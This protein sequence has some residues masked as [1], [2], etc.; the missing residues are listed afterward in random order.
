MQQI[1]EN[2]KKIFNLNGETA[3][4]GWSRSAVFE[5]NRENHPAENKITEKDS[6]FISD[7]EMAFYL[8]LEVTGSDLSVKLILA[9]SKT[10][11]IVSD[12]VSKRMLLE[13]LKL[14]A[15]DSVG[16]FTYTDK[17]IALTI[18][19]TIGGKYLKCDFI[20]FGN[21]KN[22]FVKLF[23][24]NTKG[25]SM[26]MVSADGS[27]KQNF[28]FKRFAENF[29]ASGVV[30]FGG[31]DYDINE[32]NSLVY[33]TK[34]RCLLNRKKR[35]QALC[36]CTDVS[37]HKLSVNL[38]SKVSDRRSGSENAYFVDNKL[39]KIG[40]TRVAGDERN[41]YGKWDFDSADE[42]LSLEFTPIEKDGEPMLCRCGK[43]TIVFGRLNGFLET[44]SF[45]IN[46]KNKL[47]HMIFTSL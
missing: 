45:R 38:A 17:K 39:I 21:I 12:S 3:F 9:N 35:F 15:G 23:I 16:E 22:L 8:S 2:T 13:P 25:E 47:F 32:Q 18:T 37:G 14:P 10:G 1:V 19:N 46:L 27:D 24:K 6:Y 44:D 20:D 41:P 11:E 7:G 42:N 29:T 43:L 31:L 4:S 33:Y 28:Y 30:R 34:T 40:R 5:Y 36:G 26:N